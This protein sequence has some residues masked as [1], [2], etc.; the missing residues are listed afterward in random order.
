[1]PPKRLLVMAALVL[2]ACSG[3][4]DDAGPTPTTVPPTGCPVTAA[5][6]ADALARPVTVDAGASGERS[7]AFL[8]EGDGGAGARV[9]VVAR[10]LEEEGFGSALEEV[11]RRAG[12]TVLLPDGLV[13]GAER[14]WVATVG[15]AVQIGAADDETLVVVAV[16]DPL[17]DAEAAE[18]VA[19]RLAGEVLDG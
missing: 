4:D 19:A 1:M 14:G 13:A 15:R 9:E 3:D 5:S 7:C 11:Q 2:T 10:S 12:P 18:A 17:L 16:T 6:V 8:G